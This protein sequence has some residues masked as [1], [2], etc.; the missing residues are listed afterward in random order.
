[1]QSPVVF[2]TAFSNESRFARSV[3][4]RAVNLLRLGLLGPC[5]RFSLHCLLCR[6]FSQFSFYG[7]AVGR[8]F[9]AKALKIEFFNK[10]WQWRFPTL[11][12]VIIQLPK[13]FWVHPQLSSHLYLSMAQMKSFARFNPGPQLLRYEEVRHNAC[14]L[15]VIPAREPAR[16]EKIAWSSYQLL[17]AGQTLED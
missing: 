12:L 3:L 4:K 1:M 11:L 5:L 14:R 8:F 6:F 9:F 2:P 10:H 13:F 16:S 17:K 7:P 15:R